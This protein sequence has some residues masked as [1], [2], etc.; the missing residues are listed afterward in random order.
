MLVVK[1]EIWPNGNRKKLRTLGVGVIA[2]DGTGTLA[3]GNY[4][5][6]FGPGSSPKPE[7]CKGGRVVEFP[8]L[9]SKM[10]FWH[11]VTACLVAVFGDEYLL[12]ERVHEEVPDA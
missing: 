5:A 7:Q 2:N 4:D 8:R 1:V 10:G 6:A 12:N 3:I 9:E 11:L